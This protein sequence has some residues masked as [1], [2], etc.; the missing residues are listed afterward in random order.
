MDSGTLTVAYA[1]NC[2]IN[3]TRCVPYG[4]LLHIGKVLV[5]GHALASLMWIIVTERT[6]LL[7]VPGILH[8]HDT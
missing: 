2:K 6:F 7:H 4:I 5:I 3:S 8:L 1:V